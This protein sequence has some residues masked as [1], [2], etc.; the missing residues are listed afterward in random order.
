MSL[1]INAYPAESMLMSF[2]MYTSHQGVKHVTNS[3][4]TSIKKKPQ[5]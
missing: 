5:Y 4:M 1:Q 2:V 3:G